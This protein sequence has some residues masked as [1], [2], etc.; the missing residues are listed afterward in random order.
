MEI[1][2]GEI[3]IAEDVVKKTLEVVTRLIER[4]Y[5]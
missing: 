1:T 5:E 2:V 3:V 4:Y